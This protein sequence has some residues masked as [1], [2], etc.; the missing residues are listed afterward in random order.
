MISLDPV[1]R[2]IILKEI[3]HW[4]QSKLLPEHYCDFLRNLYIESHSNE[5]GSV[6]GVKDHEPSGSKLK[7]L[8]TLKGLLSSLGIS[9]F[10]LMIF[11]YFT[12]FHPLMQ[13]ALSV[14]LVGILISIGI[15]ERAKHPIGSFSALGAGSILSL[16]LGLFILYVNDWAGAGV[17]VALVAA[18]GLLWIWVGVVARIGLL[19]LC[20]WFALLLGYLWMIQWLHAEPSWLIL[21][22]YTL[23]ICLVFYYIGKRLYNGITSSGAVLMLAS[24]LFLLLPEV[25]GLIFTEISGLVLQPALAVK[26]ALAGMAIWTQWKW[27]KN[28]S[29]WLTEHE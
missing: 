10:I 7:K 15:V 19:Q 4:R 2:K 18:C 16:F 6:S 5:Q 23:P 20:G 28:K 17:T 14:L 29:G 13:T 11:L 22:A 9:V 12:S 21:Q 24:G 27:I 25:Y 3:E 8:M 26:M 1:K